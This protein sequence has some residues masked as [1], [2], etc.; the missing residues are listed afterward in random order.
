MPKVIKT[1]PGAQN[2][3]VKNDVRASAYIGG[4]GSGK[5][6]AGILRGLEFSQQPI[7]PDTMYGPRGLIAAINYRVLMDVIVPEF[8]AMMDGTGMWKTGKKATSWY[9]SEFLARLI[10]NCGCPDPHSC[11]HEVEVLLRSLDDPDKLR[12]VTLS[13]FFI[14]EGRHVSRLAWDILY[15]R[16][17]QVGYK[18]AG[19]VCSTPNGFD[20]MWELFHPDS[21][22]KLPDAM[23]VGAATYENT[24]LPSEY[25]T[26]LE[27]SYHG[28]F[29]EQ[30]VLGHFVGITEG[31]VFFEWDGASAIQD[32]LY[33]GTLPLYSD[34]DFGMGDLNVVL[35]WQLQWVEYKSPASKETMLLPVQRYVGALEA[36]DRTSGEWARVFTEYCNEHFNGRHPSRNIGDPAG[37][38]RNQVTGTSVMEDLS[39]HGVR[40]EPAPKRPVDYAVRIANNMMADKRILVDRTNCLRLSAA[41]ASHKWQLDP[42]G[43]RTSNTPVHDWTSHYADAFRYGI[44]AVIPAIPTTKPEAA[45]REYEPGS[46]GSVFATILNRVDEDGDKWTGPQDTVELEWNPGVIRPRNP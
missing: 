28:R 12:G 19:W 31:G 46:V 44:T 2:A 8:M 23:W 17:R 29:F 18:Q 30:E 3:F 27:A 13:W 35:F 34:W 26:A 36:S 11:E 16:L 37:R 45:P 22:H 38:Q 39:M 21:P 7:A 43:N 33:D 4:L 10:A 24:H 20:W 15:G 25:I 6:F 32:V 41:L 14:D 40:M 9:K 1:N 5:T 42:S